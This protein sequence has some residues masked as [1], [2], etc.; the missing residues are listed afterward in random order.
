MPN[1]DTP[2]FVVIRIDDEV[3]FTDDLGTEFDAGP[4]VNPNNLAIA[5]RTFNSP[6]LDGL[7]FAGAFDQLAVGANSVLNQG[8][9]LLTNHV[10]IRRRQTMFIIANARVRFKLLD[11]TDSINTPIIDRTHKS[12]FL[13]KLSFAGVFDEPQNDPFVAG[14][15]HGP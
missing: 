7:A 14:G 5:N 11:P 15:G 6:F 12:P 13:S 4:N 2:N 3:Y 10:W 8:Q 9:G 1:E